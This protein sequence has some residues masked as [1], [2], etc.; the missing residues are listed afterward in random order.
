MIEQLRF[1]NEKIHAKEAVAT[2]EAIKM[3]ELLKGMLRFQY[4]HPR[5]QNRTNVDN[6][7]LTVE[8]ALAKAMKL[9]G[10]WRWN[11]AADV[12]PPDCWGRTRIAKLKFNWNHLTPPK[13]APSCKNSGVYNAA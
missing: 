6:I 10:A 9:K 7:R 5:A 1:L 13:G 4:K 11:K 3:S 8:E 12:N 2:A